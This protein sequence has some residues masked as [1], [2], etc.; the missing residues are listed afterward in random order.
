M[1]EIDRRFMSRAIR[2]AGK[3]K[4]STH[5]NPQVGCVLVR[6]GEVVGEGYHVRAGEG[7]AE[8][9]ALR[10]ASDAAKGSTAYVTLEPCSF[11]GRT[12]SCAEALVS[13]GVERVVVAMEDPDPRNAG[14]GNQILREAGIEV[15]TPFMQESAGSLVKGHARRYR[16]GMPW[17]RLKLAM[18]LDGKTA[19]G[20]GESKWITSPEARADVQRLRAMSAAIVTGVQTVID[21]DPEMSVRPELLD[22]EH[23]AEALAAERPVYVLDS[24]LRIPG[25]A[26]LLSGPQTVLVCARSASREMPGTE[27][28]AMPSDDGRVHLAPFLSE[29]ARRGHSEVLFEC[30]ATLAAS[31]VAEKLVD[32]LIIYAAPRLI[33]ATGRSLLN[34]PEID[35]MSALVDLSIQDV[36][37][38][39]PDLRITATLV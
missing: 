3:G 19:L 17:I 14:K 7:H 21:D 2:L 5:P 13:A 39:G 32:E 15:V 37:K 10:M 38:V 27:V 4:Y 22:V 8:A 16:S 25:D 9:N 18:T 24:N 31:L 36:R 11:H 30:G 1:S 23:H 29:L 26:R 6:Q 35:R 33:G 34:L 28:L 12:P 20:N